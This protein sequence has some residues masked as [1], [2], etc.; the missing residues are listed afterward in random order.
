MI[1]SVVQRFL[2]RRYAPLLTPYSEGYLDAPT[3]A[4]IARHLDACPNCQAELSALSSLAAL[5]RANPPV[6][7]QPAADLWSKLEAQIIAED[8][9][10]ASPLLPASSP[11]SSS[12]T[13]RPRLA[14]GLF[15]R[16]FAAA[17]PLVAVGVACA[18]VIIQKGLEWNP[19]VV[20]APVATAA[21]RQDIRNLSE[22]VT[23]ALQPASKT[24]APIN[25]PR[26]VEAPLAKTT[27]A[28]RVAEGKIQPAKRPTPPLQVAENQSRKER[29]N[30]QLEIR[31]TPRRVMSGIQPNAVFVASA[32]ALP[33]NVPVEP[34]KTLDAL[35]GGAMEAESESVEAASYHFKY[36]QEDRAKE[37]SALVARVP[38]RQVA[39]VA[40]GEM[41][42][43]AV[44]AAVS[45]A[46]DLMHE[47]RRQTLFS[48]AR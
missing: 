8:R 39:W 22:A 20:I 40:E 47:R 28:P 48:Y 35:S 16:A 25:K 41:E 29:R 24:A 5:L 26:P 3:R 36:S 46:D 42:A 2:C 27:I 14:W 18:L 15:G 38:L 6:A 32:D 44:P 10:P 12:G 33:S 23:I 19:P 21:P 37:T 34:R 13:Q 45:A 4:R 9:Q 43:R 1:G 30:I 11:V 17:G 7:A 31:H